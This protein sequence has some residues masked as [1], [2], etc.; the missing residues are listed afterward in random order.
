MGGPGVGAG[1]TAPF[2]EGLESGLQTDRVR[3]PI[4]PRGRI[5]VTT[6][7]GLPKPGDPSPEA[8]AILERARADAQAPLDQEVIPRRYRVGIREYFDGL[9]GDGTSGG[10]TSDGRGED[11]E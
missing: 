2:D 9:G 3:G 1:G 5:T 11:D 6:F 4:D 8:R 10:G 7:R